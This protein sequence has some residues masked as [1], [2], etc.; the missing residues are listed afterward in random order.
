MLP[1]VLIVLER[2]HRRLC[3]KWRAKRRS[4]KPIWVASEM[5]AGAAYAHATIAMD[6][7][8]KQQ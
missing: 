4:W 8:E 3:E 6:E 5:R 1:N 7:M 2:I